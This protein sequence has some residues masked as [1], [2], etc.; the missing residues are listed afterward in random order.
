[1]TNSGFEIV[2]EEQNDQLSLR[3]RGLS[4]FFQIR[5]GGRAKLTL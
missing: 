3:V 5:A 1:M 4:M 2:K